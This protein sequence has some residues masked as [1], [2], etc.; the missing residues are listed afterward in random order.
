MWQATLAP[1][2]RAMSHSLSNLE[3]HHFKYRMFRRPGDIH[4]GRPEP[5]R[6][7]WELR[8]HPSYGTLEVRVELV[9][10]ETGVC[11]LTSAPEPAAFSWMPRHSSRSQVR[12][13][14]SVP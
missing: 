8:P 2:E 1:G 12:Q 10:P 5:R 4:A 11:N 3:H 14:G 9:L 6:W 13:R 7:W